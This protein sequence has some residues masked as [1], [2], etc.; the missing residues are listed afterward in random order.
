MMG[1]GG[2]SVAMNAQKQEGALAEGADGLKVCHDHGRAYLSDDFQ[3]ELAYLGMTSSPSFV[4]LSEGY[5][6][7]TPAQARQK[8][9]AQVAEVV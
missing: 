6:Y 5:G 9:L 3:G 7:G 4:R 8:K 1:G 2:M